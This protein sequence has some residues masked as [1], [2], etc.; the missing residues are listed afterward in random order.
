M[1]D[2][3][4]Y[5]YF[6]K[7]QYDGYVMDIEGYTWKWETIVNIIG[8]MNK[9][10]MI[11][12][13]IKW[14]KVE[15]EEPAPFLQVVAEL[16][17]SRCSLPTSKDGH[18]VCWIRRSFGEFSCFPQK[19]CHLSNTKNQWH[20]CMLWSCLCPWSFWMS[21]QNSSWLES[22][23]PEKR[24]SSWQYG[25]GPAAG[26]TRWI[27]GFSCF[28]M[29]FEQ[30]FLSQS[31]FIRPTFKNMGDN[32]LCLGPPNEQIQPTIRASLSGWWYD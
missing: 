3:W 21:F 19:S 7:P 12:R 26:Y 27:M 2:D 15:N 4:G 10:N 25:V 29:S 30:I 32:N 1:D 22:A 9:K 20:P 28:P 18:V 23:S 8:S 17:C 5:P 24:Y 6:R 14:L 31:G 16:W 11:L 13:K